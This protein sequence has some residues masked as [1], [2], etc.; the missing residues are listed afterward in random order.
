MAVRP[1][2]RLRNNPIMI[3]IAKGTILLMILHFRPNVTGEPT[4]IVRCLQIQAL[5]R[6]GSMFWLCILFF[7]MLE[8]YLEVNSL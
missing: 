7:S 2:Y 5:Y 8:E 6:V 4:R 1:R 3:P